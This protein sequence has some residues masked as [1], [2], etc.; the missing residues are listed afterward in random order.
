MQ[1]GMA[2]RSTSR[3]AD[4]EMGRLW[5]S[6]L[7]VG[8]GRGHNFGAVAWSQ[9]VRCISAS[10]GIRSKSDPQNGTVFRNEN[11]THAVS[12]KM[13]DRRA[14][15][16]EYENSWQDLLALASVPPQPSEMKVYSKSAA[17]LET[18]HEQHFVL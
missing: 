18:S 13:S 9:T 16:Q 17:Y 1:G 5:F 14:K 3:F 11:N 12:K 7:C 2:R 8:S 10:R 15:Q 6:A 4:D